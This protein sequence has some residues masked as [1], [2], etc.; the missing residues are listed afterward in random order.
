MEEAIFKKMLDQ[1]RHFFSTGTTLPIAFRI[2]QLQK[3]KK[4]IQTHESEITVALKKDLGKNAIEVMTTEI[5]LIL[6]EINTVIKHLKSWAKPLKV[7]TI[8]PL[9]PGRSTIYTEPY[10]VV[11][12]IGTW[13]YPFLLIMAPLIG[14]LSA[15]NCAI[16]K[17]S[18]LATN[19]ANIIGKLI[20]QHFQPEYVIAVDAGPAETEKLLQ[21]K[22]DYIFFTGG[23]QVGKIIMQAAAK[24]LTPLTLELGGKSPCIVDES[25]NLD[26]AAR[27]II[28]G[29]MT[30][31]GQT[32]IAPDYVYVHQTKKDEL[33]QHMRN[34]LH[35]FYGDDPQKSASYAR[36]INKKHFDRLSNLITKGR[37]ILGGKTNAEDL[38]ISPTLIDDI[39]WDDPIM[40][41]EIFGPL[42]PILPYTK[43][44]DVIQTINGH[45][46]PLSLYFFTQNKF[47]EKN[48]LQH[49]SFGGGCINDCLLHFVNLHLAFGGIGQS[50]MGSYHGKYSFDTFSHRKSIYKKPFAFD[51]KLEY[52]PYNKNKFWWIRKLFQW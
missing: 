31:A 10:G 51:L 30:N 28:W 16:I 42:L 7:P 27:R 49:L 50:G 17:P 25:A 41:E 1:Q 8:L 48:V 45:S 47:A 21:E 12:I 26:F 6:K 36:I 44:N 15:G 32:C 40:Q 46:K 22:F 29:K 18:E 34:V 43:I 19:T 37:I 11:L 52:P 9:W 35:Q 4:L 39:S 23:I 14:A 38:Y 24:H 13:N 5:L 3:L 20:N 2:E 33:I